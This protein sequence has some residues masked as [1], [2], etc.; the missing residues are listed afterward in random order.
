M[1]MYRFPKRKKNNL[2]FCGDVVCV[3]VLLGLCI[4]KNSVGD[5]GGLLIDYIFVVVLWVVG[6]IYII[7]KKNFF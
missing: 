1:G 7:K 4:Y 6:D 3:I 2:L 5:G